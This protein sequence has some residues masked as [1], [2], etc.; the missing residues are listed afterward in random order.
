MAMSAPCSGPSRFRRII[1][2]TRAEPVGRACSATSAAAGP[3][4]CRRPG[5]GWPG[6]RRRSARASCVFTRS[7][8]YGASERS[9]E[10]VF[11]PT[12]SF[13]G[14]LR[15]RR[16]DEPRVLHRAQDLVPP[17]QTPAPGG[18]RGCTGWATDHPRQQRRLGSVRLATSF[19]KYI[20]AAC[21]MPWMLNEPP[22]PGRPRSCTARGCPSSG[23]PLQHEG[24][25]RLLG[26]APEGA[27]GGEEEVLHQLLGDGA[28]A[29]DEGTRP[30]CCAWRR[31][32]MRSGSRPGSLKNRRS[33]M[34]RTALTV[35]SGTSSNLTTRFFSRLSSKRYVIS[36]GS[37]VSVS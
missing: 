13:S 36:S 29:L 32:M 9:S 4:R 10:A 17:L 27:L 8:K 7:T 37:R 26:L 5:S 2:S 28:A 16:G 22:G 24:Q 35:W 1:C 19:S 18:G 21:P 30:G 15:G 31:P 11:T 3:G 6:P 25:Q 23:A 20:R 14:R 34:A 12:G 33:S